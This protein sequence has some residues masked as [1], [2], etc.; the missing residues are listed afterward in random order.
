[1]KKTTKALYSAVAGLAL[2]TS[3][4]GGTFA[5]WVDTASM[6]ATGDTIQTGDLRLDFAPRNSEWGCPMP[7]GTLAES[8]F[9]RVCWTLTPP[10]GFTYPVGHPNVGQTAPIRRSFNFADL[11]HIFPGYVLTGVTQVSTTLS[12]ETLV[13][14]LRL[15]GFNVY[16]TSPGLNTAAN[17]TLVA[18]L[19]SSETEIRFIP[20]GVNEPYTYHTD[21]NT[22]NPVYFDPIT[23]YEGEI[24]SRNFEVKVTVR[25]PAN[26]PTGLGNSDAMAVQHLGDIYLQL[27]QQV[28]TGAFVWPHTTG[29]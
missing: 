16:A 8:E 29:G 19:N 12:G 15:T 23:V 14:D 26:W 13:A 24:E 11:Q 28:S 1:M 6:N 7:T 21:I 25:F 9:G 5:S 20:E 17:Q 2:I 3:T 22:N 27:L 10:T 18:W 4:G